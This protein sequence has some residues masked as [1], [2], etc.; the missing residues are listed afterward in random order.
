MTLTLTVSLAQVIE[1]VGRTAAYAGAKNDDYTRLST[2]E[3][4][5][6]QLS[7]LISQA[8]GA[9]STALKRHIASEALTETNYQIVLEVSASFD[10]ALKASMQSS[11]ANYMAMAVTA[12]WL[13][14]SNRD[15][16][17]DY[18][19]VAA[20]LITELQRYAASKR[21]PSRPTYDN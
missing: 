8:A 5:K 3:A 16:A 9:V 18:A 14:L 10:P 11:L 1:D 4:D 15:E 13:A 21:R 19:A 20:T 2:T 12:R 7:H 17:D 6:A